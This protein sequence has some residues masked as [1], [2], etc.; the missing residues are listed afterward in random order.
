MDNDPDDIS[1]QGNSSVSKNLSRVFK[2]DPTIDH[3]LRLR[4]ENPEEEIEVAI[5]GGMEFLIF[6]LTLLEKFGIDPMRFAGILDADAGDISELSLLLLK[7]LVERKKAEGTGETHLVGRGRAISDSQVNYMITTMLDAMSWTGEL[8]ISRDLIV[9]IRHQLGGG[10]SNDISKGLESDKLKKAAVYTGAQLLE[11]GQVFSKL[12]SD[13]LKKAGVLTG[14]YLLEQGQFFSKRNIASILNVNVSTISR[15]YPGNT[16]VQKST[17]ILDLMKQI[18]K[19]E[20]PFA[21]LA[22]KRNFKEDRSE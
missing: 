17:E 6:K 21:Y 5:S 11:Q 19:S 12:V 8:T 13:E 18:H 22:K 2:D 20:T 9:L 14:A 3:Y 15:M 16:L 4:R 7:H 1:E 10:P